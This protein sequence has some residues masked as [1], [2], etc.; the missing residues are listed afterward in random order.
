MKKLSS[1]QLFTYVA[2]FGLLILI[3]V[4]VFIYQK[5]IEKTDMLSA[6]NATL[7]SR[8]NSLKVYADNEKQYEA[9]ME[10]MKPLI[11]E[12][13]NE[14]P[15][16]N[17]EEDVIMQAVITQM[18]TPLVYDVIT[19]GEDEA[20]KTIEES[21]VMGANVEEYQQEISFVETPATYQN[22]L[23]YSQLKTAIQ[24]IFDSEYVIGIKGIT[25]SK[26]GEEFDP[27]K[28]CDLNGTLELVFYSV[29]GNGKVYEKPDILPYVSGTDNFFSELYV[30]LTVQ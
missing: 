27:E 19:I 6:G 9:D 23:K 17:R 18:T 4:Y 5:N 20:Y 22:T 11:G 1:K 16:E 14:F 7:E 21:V 29:E 8:V 10:T 3:L 24:S 25:Y 26:V 13:L 2:L 12:I 15:A 30:D 28:E